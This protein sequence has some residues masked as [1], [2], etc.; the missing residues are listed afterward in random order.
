MIHTT[1][2]T[3]FG[4]LTAFLAA[5]GGT[6]IE[7]SDGDIAATSGDTASTTSALVSIASDGVDLAM[8]GLSSEQAAQIAANGA[9]AKLTPTGCMTKMVTGNVVTY[10]MNG[11]SGPYG[12]TTATGTVTATYTVTGSSLV[13]Q[14][15]GQGVKV[16]GSTLTIASTATIT[17]PVGNRSAM[18]NS[19]S[20]G[21]LPKGAALTHAGSYTAT[22]NGMCLGLNGSFTT[23]ADALEWATTVTGYQRCQNACP[24]MGQITITS[25]LR[26]TTITY[27]GTPTA[28][29][30]VNNR[31]GTVQLSC[32]S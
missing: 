10:T 9:G 24:S 6:A 8:S 20:S 19:T 23:K 22:W 18:V 7:G 28:N 26:V 17:G 11:C 5:C 32:G 4:I 13:V 14:L 15:A 29:V 31:A 27:N 16:N 21:V 25:G 12:L 30:T 1:R 3:A 2:T